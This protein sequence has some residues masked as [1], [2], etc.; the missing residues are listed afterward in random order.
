ME[1]LTKRLW[2]VAGIALTCGAYAQFGPK[3]QGRRVD[4]G[5]ME[6]NS[7]MAVAGFQM[8]KVTNE[9]PACSYKMDPSTYTALEASGI[10]ARVFQK[11]S[12]AYDVVLISS[13]SS[14]SFHDPRVCFNAQG[15]QLKDQT[16]TVLTTQTRGNIPVMLVKT[17]NQSGKEQSA[18]FFYRSPD[19]FVAAPK[20]MRMQMFMDKIKTLKNEP[21]VFYRFMP[22]GEGTT[23]EQLFKFAAAYL[24]ESGK[25]SNNFF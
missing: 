5:W 6:K 13:D 16:E 21:G 18:L 15:W 22:V 19:G 24:D 8:V 7:P 14:K 1:G 9:S 17:M 11:G 23:K 25:M 20:A 10:V 12:E 3:P 4:E 2:I